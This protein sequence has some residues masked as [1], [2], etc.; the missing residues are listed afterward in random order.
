MTI[1]K[2]SGLVPICAKLRCHLMILIKATRKEFRSKTTR[3]SGEVRGFSE[4]ELRL[5]TDAF[6]LIGD[7]TGLAK[8]D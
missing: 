1:W 2:T 4:I 3:V 8:L 5:S 7:T 6:I